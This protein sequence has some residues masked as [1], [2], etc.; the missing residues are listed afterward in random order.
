MLSPWLGTTFSLCY[1]WA[2]GVG[3]F[4]DFQVPVRASFLAWVFW[5]P[6]SWP[7]HTPKWYRLESNQHLPP[8]NR[9]RMRRACFGTAPLYLCGTSWEPFP[10]FPQRY[11]WCIYPP[12]AAFRPD[13]PQCSH[14]YCAWW[15]YGA[16]LSASLVSIAPVKV[17]DSR[18]CITDQVAQQVY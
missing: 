3:A 15:V 8:V 6:S 11:R 2:V 12:G 16:L 9:G 5:V 18:A 1:E 14:T 10:S 4:S 13:L 17:I 7:L